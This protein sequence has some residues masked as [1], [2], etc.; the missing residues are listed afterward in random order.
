VSTIDQRLRVVSEF[1]EDERER[2]VSTL[3][4]KLDRR[5]ERWDTEAVELELSV[6]ERDTTS[7]KVVLEAWIAGQ[8]RFVATST[9]TDL[10]AALLEVRGDL[11][12]QIDKHVN[13]LTQRGRR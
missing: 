12:T 6:K 8:P 7:Q 3:Q 11:F 2:L 13:K 4:P 9:Q 1:R 10:D 5:L